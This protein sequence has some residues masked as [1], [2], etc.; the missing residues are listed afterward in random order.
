MQLASKM[1]F[2]GAQFLALLA[3]DLWIENGRRA[4]AMAQHLRH[5]VAD[6]PFVEIVFPVEAN[7]VFARLPLAL[8][9]PLQRHTFFWPWD[10]TKGLVRWMCAFDSE[11]Q[12][13]DTFVAALKTLGSA[14]Q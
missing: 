8:L 12:D 3:D 14:D 10:A 13:I 11:R 4:N 9:E 6:L 1:R 5:A 7:A 2:L